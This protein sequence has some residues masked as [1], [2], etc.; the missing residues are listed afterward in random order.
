MTTCLFLEP[1]RVIA[2]CQV[3]LLF[4]LAAG[5]AA[6]G[7]SAEDAALKDRVLQLVDRL[8]GE[9]V[10]A[11]ETAMA[12]LIKLGPRILPLLPDPATV[13][14]TERKD[15]LTRVRAALAEKQDAVNLGATKVTVQGKGIRLS[16]AL[17]QLQKQSGNPISDL[18]EQLGVEVTNPGFDIDL[19]DKPFF[20]ALDEI[21]RKADVSTNFASGDGSIGIMGGTPEN[22]APVCQLRASRSFNTAALF[23]SSSSRSA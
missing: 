13:K 10:E 1:R 21:V 17:Q 23:A 8:D 4:F 20:E 14:T 3:V 19:K 16:E 18:R 12:S 22:P 15:R 6:R 2:S 9:K 11:R 7:Q 5:T